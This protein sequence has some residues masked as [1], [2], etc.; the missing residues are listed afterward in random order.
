MSKSE[1]EIIAIRSYPD[2][3]AI[4]DE[5]ASHVDEDE[6]KTCFID[7]LDL[8]LFKTQDELTVSLDELAVSFI[9]D[10]NL[11]LGELEKSRKFYQWNRLTRKEYVEV[12]QKL[13]TTIIV[14]KLLTTIKE[15]C[16]ELGDKN[17]CGMLETIKRMT[18]VRVKP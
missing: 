2:N 8:D 3:P 16:L 18:R 14:Q 11:A 9:N 7:G 13:L 6:M 1:I 12:V 17:F 15:K 5:I 10:L 4:P